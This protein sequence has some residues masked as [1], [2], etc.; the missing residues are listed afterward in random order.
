M[1]EDIANSDRRAFSAANYNS[2]SS[3]CYSI[4]YLGVTK[5]QIGILSKRSPIPYLSP[6][7]T[8]K[9]VPLV[10]INS[11]TA[12]RGI[13]NRLL[14][15]LVSGTGHLELKPDI[16]ETFIEKEAYEQETD[17][18]FPNPEEYDE[19][20][21]HTYARPKALVSVRKAD[22]YEYNPP[23]H[24]PVNIPNQRLGISG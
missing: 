14:N 22:I 7:E 5:G 2:N 23:I 10:L 20:V 1:N 24:K 19:F 15:K 8:C 11:S 12:N 4:K 17:N 13:S 3:P 18:D 16:Q 21:I 6:L 9:D